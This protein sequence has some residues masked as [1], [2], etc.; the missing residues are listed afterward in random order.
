MKANSDEMHQFV[1]VVQ[2]GSISAAA[3]H[4][5]MTP[6]AVSRML[7]RLERKLSTTLI[8]RT[9]RR[10]ELTEEGRFFFEQ[11]QVILQQM[12]QL[13][14][15]LC[16]CRQSP[17]GRLSVNAATPFMLHAIM[18]YMAEFRAR[19]PYIRLEL[20]TD[21][22]NIDLLERRT[23]IAIR[24]GE[25][26]DS[27]LH[28]RSLGTTRRF[29]VASPEYLKQ[30]GTP[31]TIEALNHHYL[32]GFTEP[33][34]LNRWPLNHSGNSGYDI[35]PALS[36]SNGETLRQLALYGNGIACLSHFMVHEDLS[37]GR[38]V[39]ILDTHLQGATQ[40]INAVYYRN[41]QLAQRISCFLDFMQE[42][43]CPL[44]TP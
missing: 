10:M 34:T 38:L 42:K 30:H 44:D 3:Q 11:A 9:T 35:M 40:R 14:A 16:V 28:A 36:A 21:E 43:L 24:I 31:N 18:P 5:N 13:E 41:A 39:S 29:L 23:D 2:H 19:F 17:E 4:L 7:S 22:R 32:L 8:N 25:L 6:S 1:A 12:A 27:S 15:R 33:D 20:T 37:A 26:N